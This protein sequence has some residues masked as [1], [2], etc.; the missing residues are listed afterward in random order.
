MANEPRPGGFGGP[1]RR[2]AG[3]DP[4]VIAVA[5]SVAV[6]IRCAVFLDGSD[7]GDFKFDVGARFLSGRVSLFRACKVC[8]EV[9]WEYS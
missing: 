8:M 7:D 6:A 1:E 9:G 5:R 4:P 3:R 2:A